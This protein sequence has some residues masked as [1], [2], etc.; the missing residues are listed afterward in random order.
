MSSRSVKRQFN[1]IQLFVVPFALAALIAANHADARSA[2]GERSIEAVDSRAAGPPIMAIVSLRQQRVTVYDAKGWILR[3]PVSSGQTGRETPSGV[4]SVLQ[5]RA[6]HYSNLYD[7]AYMPHMQ[8]ITW[9]GIALHGGA[10][11][12]Y[13]A[14]HGCVR[15]PFDFAARLFE[16]TALGMRVIVAPADVAPVDIAHPALFRP[17]PDAG[18]VAAARAAEADVALRQADRTRLASVTAFREANLARVTVRSTEIQKRRA[19]AELAAAEASLGSASSAEAKALAESAQAEAVA[20]IAALQNEWEGAQA[21]LQAKLDAAARTREVAVAAETARVAAAQAAREAALDGEPVSVFISRKTQRLY[22]RRAFQS[23]LET[24]V[25][26]RD[27]DRPIG[28]HVFTAME[29]N[30]ETDL[31]WSVVSLVGAGVPAAESAA[32]DPAGALE[33][34]VISQEVLDRIAGM[35]LPRSSLIISDEALSPETGKETDF[36]IVLSGEP[37]GGIKIRRRGRA[38]DIR[39]GRPFDRAFDRPAVWRPPFAGR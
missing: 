32:S 1:P 2:A 5:K 19:E 34:I 21:V 35:A 29:R 20:R 8:R 14:S 30:N 38:A 17:R 31:R 10:L 28:T 37:Q 6:E 33:R 13:P 39:Y 23:I 36:V 18:A 4:F 25:M 16:T 3:A 24:E 22:V 15:M 9:S 27:A 26:V 11:P 12:G 7:D